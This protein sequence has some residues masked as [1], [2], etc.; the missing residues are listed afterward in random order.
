M[1]IVNRDQILRKHSKMCHSVC[2]YKLYLFHLQSV[3]L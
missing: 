1:K 2:S 3:E